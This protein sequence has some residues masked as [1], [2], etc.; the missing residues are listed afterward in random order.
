MILSRFVKMNPDF[1]KNRLM[2][3][4][5]LRAISKLHRAIFGKKPDDFRKKSDGIVKKPD[6]FRTFT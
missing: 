3:S 1:S 5:N 6:F 4:G 2:F